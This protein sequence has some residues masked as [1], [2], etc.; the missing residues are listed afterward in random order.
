MVEFPCL[1]FVCQFLHITQSDEVAAGHM[2]SH[3]NHM[4]CHMTQARQSYLCAREQASLPVPVEYTRSCSSLNTIGN[5]W[6]TLIGE[7]EYHYAC[8]Q[9]CPNGLFHI[10]T[11]QEDGGPISIN[12]CVS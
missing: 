12:Y 2:I 7:G 11:T 5:M 1:R 9:Y 10:M 8:K 4:V 3:N 6:D